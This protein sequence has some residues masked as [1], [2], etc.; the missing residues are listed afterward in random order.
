VDGTILIN[1]ASALA[2]GVTPGDTPGF[3]VEIRV[4]GSYKLSSNLIVPN[5]NTT[6]ILIE[7]DNVSIDLNG[8]SI[9]GP[10]V[11]N[12]APFKP[13][14]SCAPVGG[15]AGI[16][17]GASN[18]IS[19]S[20]GT[21]RGMGDSEIILGG[22]GLRIDRLNTI[23]NGNEGIEVSGATVTNCTSLFN[24]SVGIS[25]G[26]MAIGNYVS[27]NGNDGISGTGVAKNNETLAN[28]GNGIFVR[29]VISENL[30]TN[31]GSSDIQVACPSTVIGNS[32]TVSFLASSTG[33]VL[34]NNSSS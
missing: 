30:S 34:S 20:N 10:T 13:T 24:R 16:G 3:P 11:C 21:I 5:E 19:I 8:F 17:S 14:T 28:A 1:Q 22:S 4:P 32:G 12:G 6:A 7:A 33:C 9:I 25:F 23:G 15:G 29:G 27:G 2:G 26:G 31:N 18:G